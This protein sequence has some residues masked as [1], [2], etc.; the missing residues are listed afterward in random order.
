M[1]NAIKH[2]KKNG[3]IQVSAGIQEGKWN[4]EISNSTKQV[5]DKNKV[6][7]RKYKSG[8]SAGYGIGMSIVSDM[9]RMHD[10]TLEYIDQ[11]GEA[12]VRVSGSIV[13]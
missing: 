3:N 4:L 11:K 12:V 6:I 7:V 13:S 8:T 9:C 5:V 10:L 2:N 1:D